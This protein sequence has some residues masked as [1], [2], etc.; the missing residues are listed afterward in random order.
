MQDYEGGIKHTHADV[1]VYVFLVPVRCSLAWPA[2]S[3]D[4]RAVGDD[5]RADLTNFEA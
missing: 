2:G 1:R 4:S 3:S 5:T